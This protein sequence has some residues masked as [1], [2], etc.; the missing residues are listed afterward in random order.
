MRFQAKFFLSDKSQDSYKEQGVVI[1]GSCTVCS[2]YLHLFI[3][4]WE[5]LEL[6]DGPLYLLHGI[7]NAK[8]RSIDF[9]IPSEQRCTFYVLDSESH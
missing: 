8:I 1:R 9:K 2:C 4:H 7:F 3:Q 5:R 6:R